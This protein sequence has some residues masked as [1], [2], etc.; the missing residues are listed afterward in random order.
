M[1]ILTNIFLTLIMLFI[2]AKN[3]ITQNLVTNPSFENY[4]SCP[5]GLGQIYKAI[6]WDFFNSG[7]PDYFNT[8][9]A[10]GLQ[11]PNNSFGYQKAASG[12]A[13]SGIITYNNSSL[14][15]E[16][17]GDSLSSPLIISQKYF[18][19]FKLNRADDNTVVGYSSNNIGIKLSTVK[20]FSVNIDNTA[21]VYNN[22]IITDT[23]NWIRITGSFIA[24]SVYK[25]LM[26]G[27]FF[28]DIN[29]SI[30]NESSGPF[31]YYYIDDVCLSTDSIL[32]ANFSTSIKKNETTDKL[33]IYP[34]PANSEISIQYK[35]PFNIA[36]Y[37][38][39]GQKIIYSTKS[40]SKDKITIETSRWKNGIY[41][42]TINNNKTAKIFVNH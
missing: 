42:I 24:D 22:T 40:K 9:G 15:R 2:I 8:C 6:G 3:G 11:V 34:N 21:H 4:S 33:L 37:N 36:I 41:I 5:S 17:I 19:S 7:S 14:S 31:A 28:D 10:S 25:Y 18:V 38:I 20:S 16:I 29:T 30:I 13:Y 26:I 32:C 12:N 27:N 35:F 23:S 1:K 39:L